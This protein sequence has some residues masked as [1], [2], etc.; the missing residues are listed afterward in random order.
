[1]AQ[2]LG[3]VVIM[4]TNEPPLSDFYIACRD[5]DVEFVKQMLEKAEYDLNRLEPNNSTPLHA[6]C[7]YGHK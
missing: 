5:R 3:K 7:Y 2:H 4:A 1:K 6:A